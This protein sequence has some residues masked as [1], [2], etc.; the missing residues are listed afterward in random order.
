MKYFIELG[1][2]YN[3]WTIIDSKPY[4]FPNDNHKHVKCRCVCGHESI[5]RLDRIIN[6]INKGCPE[7]SWHYKNRNKKTVG[8][9]GSAFFFEIKGN[10]NMRGLDFNITM[11]Y[12]WD[13]FVKQHGLCALSGLVLTL[14]DETIDNNKPDRKKVSAS[15]DRIDSSKGYIEGNVQWVHKWVNL[16][17]GAM[18][19]EQFIGVC[20]V[21]SKYNAHKED[22]FDPSSM[23][24]HMP[25]KLVSGNREGATT[26]EMMIQTNNSPH[27]RAT[28]ILEGEDIV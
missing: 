26:R 5:T 2:R 28:P 27:E 4:Y 1:A 24:G 21:I 10:A 8:L 20:N 9:L 23:N 17:K 16:M 18:S 3:N 7:C 11:N 12:L 14:N 22:N 6:G 13:L 19:D 15:V 25:R